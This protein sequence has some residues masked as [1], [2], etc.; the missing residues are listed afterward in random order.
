MEEEGESTHTGYSAPPS[1]WPAVVAFL[2]TLFALTALLITPQWTVRVVESRRQR[3]EA[4][5]YRRRAV[6]PG[7]HV[8]AYK[9]S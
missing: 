8:S 2:F 7:G 9:S 6:R 5:G 3:I 4:E 1:R